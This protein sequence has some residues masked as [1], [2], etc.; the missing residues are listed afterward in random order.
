MK[1]TTKTTKNNT[2][3]TAA[4]IAATDYIVKNATAREVNGDKIRLHIAANDS[5]KIVLKTA[6]GK[7][8]AHI[9]PNKNGA[10]VYVHE[11]IDSFCNDLP[12]NPRYTTAASEKFSRRYQLEYNGG[13]KSGGDYNGDI[14]AAVLFAESIAYTDDSRAALDRSTARRNAVKTAETEA[15]AKLVRV[16][17]RAEARRLAAEAAE[18]EAAEAE[19]QTE[20]EAAEA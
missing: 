15:A 1:N 20:A 14:N 16:A 2:T 5:K 12:Q 10:L 8:A 17:D 9:Y 6:D 19:A 11:R 4:Q 7:T 3:K 13:S 18:A